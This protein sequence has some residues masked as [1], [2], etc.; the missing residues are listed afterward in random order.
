MRT[1]FLK[2]WGRKAAVEVSL[3]F[4]TDSQIRKLNER[5][6]HKNKA[7]DVLSFPMNVKDKRAK[8]LGDIVIS[9]DTAKRDAKKKGIRFEEELKFL[10]IH[11][12]L[13]LLGYDHEVSEREKKR[14]ER[15]ER[16]YAKFLGGI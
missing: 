7:T 2:K 4:V 10:L 15:K 5:Y 13:H 12:F 16:Q 3:V 14:M 11:G 9:A 6:R 8:L 1:L